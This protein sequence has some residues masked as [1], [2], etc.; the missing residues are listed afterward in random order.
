[1]RAH[2]AQL[3]VKKSAVTTEGKEQGS[4]KALSPSSSTTRKALGRSVSAGSVKGDIKK[5]YLQCNSC[6]WST[7]QANIPDVKNGEIYK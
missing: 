7:R 5:L 3:D 2:V 6:Q 4:P 1:M